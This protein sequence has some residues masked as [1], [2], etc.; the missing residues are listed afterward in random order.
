MRRLSLFIVLA[1]TA[2]RA[3]AQQ[4]TLRGAVVGEAG[5]RIPYAVVVLDPG[6]AQRFTD[7][8]GLFAVAQV[9]PGRYRLQVRQVGY[10]PFDS[11]VDI[12]PQTPQLRIEL[13]RIAV[14]LADISV[15]I[16]RQCRSP[17]PPD[18]G[19]PLDEIFQQLRQNAERYH[20]LTTQFPFVAIMSRTFSNVRRDFPDDITRD[21]VRHASWL[22]TPYRPGDMVLPD[23][24]EHRPGTHVVRMVTIEQLA[25]SLFWTTHCFSAAG[26]DTLMGH[27]WLRVDFKASTRLKTPDVNGSAYL[28][29]DS[30]R[31]GITRF[32]VT[33]LNQVAP[34]IASWIATTIFKDL[35]PYMPLED[36]VHV[37]TE[38]T[39]RGP[40]ALIEMLEDQRLL[41]VQFVRATFLGGSARDT[42]P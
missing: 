32:S 6:F 30:Y 1:F 42:N 7:E 15:N 29:P 38:T 5:E 14:R 41:Q 33:K 23:T 18:S 39:E 34:G 13:K 10:T 4:V 8:N 36:R 25:D 2:A 21:T 11:T 9:G 27:S 16:A 40:G 22:A 3:V 31:L 37:V 35:R 28:D 20:L 26:L 19:A 24:A 17:T 12:T